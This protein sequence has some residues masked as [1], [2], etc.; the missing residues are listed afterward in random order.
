MAV[1]ALRRVRRRRGHQVGPKHHLLHL[2]QELP[3]ARSLRAQTQPKVSLFE[4][5]S[6]LS[7]FPNILLIFLLR[8]DFHVHRF[9]LRDAQRI[10]K[11]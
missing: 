1:L 10:E 8:I 9:W 6:L 5:S 7:E 3:L 2:R 4:K 11:S